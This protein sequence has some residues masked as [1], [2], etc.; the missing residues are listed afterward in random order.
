[1]ARIGDYNLHT[2][3]TGSF[4]LDGGAMF[5]IVPKPLWEKRIPGDG[6]NRIRLRAR[7]LLVEGN[8]RLTLI[9][10]GIGD[11]P[12]EKFRHI[13]GVEFESGNLVGSL[14][15]LGFSV[16]DV[17]DVV[18]THLHFDHCGGASVRVGDRLGVA[19]PRAR[20]HVQREHWAWAN[21]PGPRER[22]SFLSE[23]L[24]PL[25]ESGQ[26]RL[27]D[28]TAEIAPGLSV[29]TVNGHT[30]A[31]QL[32]KV[33]DAATALVYVADLLPTVHHVAPAWN[34]AYDLRPLTTMSEKESLLAEAHEGR[35][36]LFFEHDPDVEVA[37]VRQ[38]D[39]GYQLTDFRPL[40]EL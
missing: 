33:Q 16:D 35:W 38:G 13:F 10:A 29:R 6:S 3:D 25:S 30:T 15:E 5:G 40:S 14:R 32:V 9:D 31:M 39:R 4:A 7:C 34:M 12:D 22:A 20:Y 36:H 1:M 19:F 27:V 18:L 2:V 28:K 37:S 17:T 21:D 8:G 24:S 23:N 26:L 11:K